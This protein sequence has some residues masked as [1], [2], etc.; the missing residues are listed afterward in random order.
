MACHAWHHPH[1]PS[2]L[3]LLQIHAYMVQGKHTVLGKGHCAQHHLNGGSY[4]ASMLVHSRPN[5]ASLTVCREQEQP[6]GRKLTM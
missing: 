5:M 4:D 1:S 3:Y 6:G 2:L